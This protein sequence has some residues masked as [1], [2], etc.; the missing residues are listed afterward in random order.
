MIIARAPDG[1][2]L[3]F[4]DYFAQLVGHPRKV[5][6]GRTVADFLESIP[7]YGAS[8]RPLAANER[9]L[10]RALRGETVIGF[11]LLTETAGGERIPL[12]INAAPIRDARGDLI[13]AIT[14]NTDM[15]TF[16]ALERSLREAL[17]QRESLYRELTHRVKNHLQIMSGLISM[18]ARDPALTV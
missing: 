18:E 1:K 3:R 6:E 17:A 15:R 2:I 4:S 7:I 14:S 13:G 5:W 11:E 9:P 10:S 8:G 16:K 12:I